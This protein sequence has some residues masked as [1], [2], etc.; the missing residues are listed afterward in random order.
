M[1][2]GIERTARRVPQSVVKSGRSLVIIINDKPHDFNEDFKMVMT[3]M[4]PNPAFPPEQGP[5]GR[6][7]ESKVDCRPFP[8]RP[9]FANIDFS[10][11]TLN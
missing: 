11:C 8:S 7:G 1:L 3:S 4:L 2:E 5:L 9:R 6:T 10:K